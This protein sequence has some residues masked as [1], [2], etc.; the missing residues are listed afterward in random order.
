MLVIFKILIYFNK[1]YA[2]GTIL[3]PRDKAVNKR[4][5]RSVFVE[6]T[7]HSKHIKSLLYKL[8]I[9]VAVF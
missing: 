6:L 2:L 3:G 5:K 8:Q 7:L 4:N 1:S 9:C